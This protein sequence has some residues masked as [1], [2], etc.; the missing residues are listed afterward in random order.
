MTYEERVDENMHSIF[1]LAFAL[2]Q[3]RSQAEA[4][5]VMRYFAMPNTRIPAPAEPDDK[6]DGRRTHRR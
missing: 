6:P 5:R 4:L 1:A 3:C 2:L